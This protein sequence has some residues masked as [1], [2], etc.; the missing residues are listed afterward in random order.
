MV[1]SICAGWPCVASEQAVLRNGFSI[2]HERHAAMDDGKVTRLFLTDDDKS[3]V[4]VAT[5]E[6]SGFEKIETP[7]PQPPEL[8]SEN[9]V[10][11]AEEHAGS[12]LTKTDIAS[13][14]N[15]ASN[16]HGIDAD[17]IRSVIQAESRF[18]TDAVSKK[19]ARGLMQLMPATARN[20]GV[21]NSFDA[22]QNVMG[23]TRYLRELLV[24]FDYD[25][26]KALAA[27][28]AGPNRVEQYKGVPPYRETRAYVAQIVNDFNKAVYRRAPERYAALA[29]QQARAR[30][31]SRAAAL[32]SLSPDSSNSWATDKFAKLPASS[33]EKNRSAIPVHE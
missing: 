19:G 16:N 22:R 30:Q 9:A 14:V 10:T 5:A 13:I 12:A 6:I 26:I 33:K 15:E 1:M 24:K 7:A 25:L 23:G 3:F 2:Q 20:L 11:S 31:R 27:Y 4:D 18:R 32:P 29:S 8:A 21:T 28:N 17:L